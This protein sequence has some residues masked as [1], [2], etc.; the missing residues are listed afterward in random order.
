M[1][2]KMS[3]A[4]RILEHVNVWHDAPSTG[5]APLDVVQDIMRIHGV[6]LTQENV[7][8]HVDAMNKLVADKKIAYR[9]RRGNTPAIIHA[10]AEGQKRTR[11]G[12]YGGGRPRLGD[13]RKR[14]EPSQDPDY[15]A[16][17]KRGEVT[18]ISVRVETERRELN[19]SLAF[20]TNEF[21]GVFQNRPPLEQLD[22]GLDHTHQWL[23]HTSFSNE[24]LLGALTSH[25]RPLKS[26]D[27]GGGAKALTNFIGSHTRNIE[28]DSPSIIKTGVYRHPGGVSFFTRPPCMKCDAIR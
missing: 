17:V 21:A 5:K 3:V 18:P 22:H 1:A 25:G 16:A 8:E 2:K 14:T 6:P 28:N 24:Q 11:G 13:K 20:T 7:D 26:F 12:D 10:I 23:P 15:L 9:R 27:T 19:N 4:D